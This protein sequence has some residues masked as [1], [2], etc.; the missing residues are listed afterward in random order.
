MNFFEWIQL[1]VVV[2][3]LWFVAYQ[4][5]LMRKA[6]NEQKRQAKVQSYFQIWMS[7]IQTCHMPI[8]TGE[9]EIAKRINSL[10]PYHHVNFSEARKCH[11]ADAVLDFYECIQLCVNAGCLDK[12]VERIWR[13]SI[14][15]ELLN[16]TLRIHWRKFHNPSGNN[17]IPEKGALGIYHREFL[18]MVEK[19][20]AIAEKT[21]PQK[22]N[23]NDL[24]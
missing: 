15:Y 16:P 10:S 13:D 19:Y 6:L 23:D 24:P 5:I 11:F 2:G 21:E 1:T 14:P 17:A 3:S 12:E 20:I 8:A 22:T 4:S 7:H 9:E 18:E